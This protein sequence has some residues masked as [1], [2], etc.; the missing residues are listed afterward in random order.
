MRWLGRFTWDAGTETLDLPYPPQ[1]WRETRKT[2]GGA[3][4]SAAGVLAGYVARVDHLLALPLRI[5]AAEWPQLVAMLA[6]AETGG[7]LTWY[8]DRNDLLTAFTVSIE[9]PLAGEDFTPEPDGTYPK[10]R[11]APLVLRNA[12]DQPFDLDYFAEP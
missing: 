12:A 2:I 6:W 8:P 11:I 1:Q 3:G 10:V 5:T 9:S 4:R 7:T